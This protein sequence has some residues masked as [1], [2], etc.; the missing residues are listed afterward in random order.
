MDEGS[1]GVVDPG[2][3]VPAGEDLVDPGVG[4]SF[5][6]FGLVREHDCGHVGNLNSAAAV[7]NVEAGLGEV[8]K[9]VVPKGGGCGDARRRGLLK[10]LEGFFYVGAARTT[11]HGR[12]LH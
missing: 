7:C 4:E 12:L 11:P 3:H 5:E 2:G 10:V 1:E 8:S 6:S 9:D